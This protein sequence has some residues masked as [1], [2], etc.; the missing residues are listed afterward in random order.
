M[1]RRALFG[2]FVAGAGIAAVPREP[3]TAEAAPVPH[4]E[5]VYEILSGRDGM[6]V[7]YRLVQDEINTRQSKSLTLLST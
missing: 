2:V 3:K 4:S 1:K 7:G 5:G 6:F